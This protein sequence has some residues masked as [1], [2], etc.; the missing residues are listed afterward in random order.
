MNDDL[1][2]L[3]LS[4]RKITCCIYVVKQPQTLPLYARYDTVRDMIGSEQNPSAMET[5]E[6]APPTNRERMMVESDIYGAN[7]IRAKIN[8]DA[9]LSR[10]DFFSSPTK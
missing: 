6:Q 2:L 4:F 10:I 1:T 8:K 3:K 9:V 5:A 7:E